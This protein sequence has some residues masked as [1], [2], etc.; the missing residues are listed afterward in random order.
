MLVEKDYEDLLRLFNKHKVKYCIVGAFAVAFH[1]RPRYTKDIDIL[2]EPTT[3]NGKKIIEAIN[4]FGF[5]SLKLTQ[6]D[7]VKPGQI[8]Q[9]GFEPV[10]IDIVTSISG[11]PFEK[12]WKN[13]RM[14]TY[15]KERVFFLGLD[16]LITN[17][18]KAGREIDAVDLQI[19]RDVKRKKK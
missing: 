7:F 4:E 16:E 3:E 15:G 8:I 10:R 5:G 18:K 1:G 14:G 12:V 6:D 13:K 17:K 11:C 19:L 9:L 2:V